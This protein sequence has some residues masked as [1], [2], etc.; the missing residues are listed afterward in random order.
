MS[1]NSPYHDGMKSFRPSEP[2]SPR[3]SDQCESAFHELKQ[4]LTQ[5]PVLGFADPKNHMYCIWMHVWMDEVM[6]MGRMRKQSLRSPPHSGFIWTCFS[7]SLKGP[8]EDSRFWSIFCWKNFVGTVIDVQLVVVCLV[9][10][11]DVSAVTDQR[12]FMT[13]FLEVIKKTVTCSLDVLD[14]RKEM[15]MLCRCHGV[16]QIFAGSE[17]TYKDVQ[18]VQV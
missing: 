1:G 10:V 6:F 17:V 5:A 13:P 12:V 2:F 3:W 16:M 8:V 14:I 9:V 18:A 15:M 4:R 7:T 11:Y